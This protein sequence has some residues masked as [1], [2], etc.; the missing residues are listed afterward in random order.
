MSRRV[1]DQPQDL[2]PVLEGAMC[3]GCG[4]CTAI[5]PGLQ[6]ELDE[7][8]QIWQPSGPGGPAAASVCPAIAVDFEGLHDYIFPGR[9]VTPLGVVEKVFLAQSTDSERNLAASS[10]GLIKELILRLMSEDEVDGVI[11]LAEVSGLTF[12][13]RLLRDPADVDL[14]PGSIYHHVPFDRALSILEENEGKFVLVAIPCQLEGIFTYIRQVRPDLRDRVHTTIGLLCGWLYSHHALRAICRYKGIDFDSIRRVSYRGGGPV[15]KLRISTA[16][17]ET[18]I[19]RRI[20]FGYQVAFDRSFNTTRCHLCVNHGNFLADLVVGDAWLPSTVMTRTGISL[21]ICRR[22]GS[23]DLLDELQ[24]GGRI[25]CTE[26]SGDEIVESQTRRMVY[27]DMA[28][29]YGDYLR[30]RGEHAPLMEGPNRPVAEL[31]SRRRVERFHR[32]LMAKLRLQHS[33]KYRLLWWRKATLGAP[34]MLRRYATWFFVRV[35]RIK[36]I[37]GRREE[38]PRDKTKIFR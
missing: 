25:E 38:V 6:L 4:A 24:A 27:G 30:E 1:Q 11:A 34:A 7:R 8:N 16:G 23:A 33:R 9:D 35:V 36:S 20:D 28:Y 29:A 26:V 37:L 19:S 31:I 14:L 2:T 13:P 17:G 18:A 22:A 32:E 5:E 10:G 3:I 12:E 21:V 15:G